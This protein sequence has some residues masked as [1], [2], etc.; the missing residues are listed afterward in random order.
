MDHNHIDIYCERTDPA[1]WAEPLNAVSN[2]AFLIAA[3]FA[4]R[5][6]QKNS[7]PQ[8]INPGSHRGSNRSQSSMPLPFDSLFLAGIIAVIGVGSFLFH[9]LATKTALM[10][11]VI[12]ILIYQLAFL[13]LYGRRVM[14]LSRARVLILIVGFLMLGQSSYMAKDILNGSLGYAPALIFLIA[15]AI[16]HYATH[17]VERGILFLAA[18]I[19][20]LSLTFR[21]I[22]MAICNALPIGIHYMWHI[23]N[24]IVLY[25][26]TR[27]YVMNRYA[28]SSPARG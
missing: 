19:F 5:L 22:D 4:F 25:L 27:A 12:P 13:S 9:T 6:I 15:Y 3:F 8:K 16:Y 1:F 21:S 17:K 10:A 7:Y 14:E 24:A 23:L 11:D 2:G 18:G 28:R 20:T 26:T